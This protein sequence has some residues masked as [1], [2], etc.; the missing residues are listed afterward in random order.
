MQQAG[1]LLFHFCVHVLPDATAHSSSTLFAISTT[2]PNTDFS[3]SISTEL[4]PHYR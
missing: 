1:Y 4:F 3:F 2:P